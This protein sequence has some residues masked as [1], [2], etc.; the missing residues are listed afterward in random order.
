MEKLWYAYWWKT[1]EKSR[2][3]LQRSWLIR[4][5]RT[6]A[7]GR[8]IA[9][10]EIA[11][12]GK[13][14]P[15]V[16]SGNEAAAAWKKWERTLR[17]L[18]RRHRK[19]VSRAGRSPE[20]AESAEDGRLLCSWENPAF[21][22]SMIEQFYRERQAALRI[23]RDGDTEQLILVEPEPAFL[24]GAYA[25]YNYITVVTDWAA[26]YEELRE[27]IYQ[28]SGLLLRCR[29]DEA[30]LHFPQKPALVLDMRKRASQPPD[31]YRNLPAGS[32]YLDMA[33]NGEKRRRLYAK[34]R[35]IRYFSLGNALD[36]A[37]HNTV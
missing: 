7:F 13:A 22:L 23:E 9:G 19:A 34:C 8:E 3:E 14:Q 21:P 33:E 1:E 15:A 4:E 37:L 27:R 32:V 30:Q 26:A 35:E 10:Y 12:P 20:A 24:E 28:D 16:Q 17:K 2:W 5:C 25:S 31:C 11:L 18:Q 6:T 36:T 29:E